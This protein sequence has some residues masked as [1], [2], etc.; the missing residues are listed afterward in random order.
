MKEGSFEAGAD[1]RTHRDSPPSALAAPITAGLLS[2]AVI[3]VGFFGLKFLMQERPEFVGQPL[4]TT[5]AELIQECP[6][7]VLRKVSDDVSV[8]QSSQPEFSDVRFDLNGR[9]DYRGLR[10]IRDM[11]GHF[12]GR[13]VLTNGFDEPGYLLFKCPHPRTENGGNDGLVAGD[14]KLRTSASGMQDNTADAWFWSGTLEP[15]G[16]ATLEVSYDVTSLKGVTYRVQG[17]DGAQVKQLR[18]TLQREDLAAMRVD[19]GDGTRRPADGTIVWERRDFLAPDFFSATIEE[20]RSLFGSISQLLEIGPLISLLFLVAVSA[21]L[22]MRQELTAFQM[23]TI[24]AGYAVYF[25]LLLYLAANI[26]FHW[27][28]AI[29]VVVPG[30]L[31]ANYARWLV[32]ARIGVLGA[33]VFLLLYQVFPT[34][35]AFAGWNR[36]MVLLCLGLV[37]LAVLI[38]LQNRTLKLRAAAALGLLTLLF[39]APSLSAAEVQVILPAELATRTAEAKHELTNSPLALVAFQ[40]AEYKVKQEAAYFRVEA[41]VS[42]EAI[43]AGENP[44][45]LFSAPVYLEQAK[46]EPEQSARLVTLTNRLALFI[47]R[48]GSGALRLSYRVPAI[49]REGKWHAQLPLLLGAPGTLRLESTSDAI[50]IVGGSVWTKSTA[51]NMTTYDIG[52]AGEESLGIEWREGLSR[53]G[54]DQTKPESARDIY[55]IGLTR[56]QNLTIINSDG[57]CTHFAEYE[58]PVSQPAEFRLR[59]PPGARLLSVSVNHVEI[60]S[61]RVADQVC[62]IRLPARAPQQTAHLVSFRFAYPP[63]P[64]GFS[65]T[66]ELALPELF[67]TAGLLEWAVALPPGFEARVL[68]CGLE[69]QK[70]PAELE[71]FGDYGRILKQRVNINLAKE[72][73][74]PALVK[75]SMKYRQT[76][77]GIFA[78]GTQTNLNSA[79]N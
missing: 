8:I 76:V 65:G 69:T 31:L 15:H 14:L 20:G 18:V 67:Q 55:G 52:V 6:R 50:E 44:V 59:L 43:R 37:T 16:T 73:A 4:L 51:N 56:A 13:Y 30:A 54:S 39:S 11:S 66:A 78:G 29:A 36:G 35:A 33:V 24:A 40:P 27:A 9:R 49:N 74:P 2:W 72:L 38:N 41:A 70:S 48:P 79:S 68:S 1:H 21:V 64:L 47:Q 12:L 53:A 60:V 75:L 77:P 22:L 32:G 23:F 3:S 17:Q 25:P 71:R 58:V 46:I 10:T 28:L 19:T 62:V 42:L 45:S 7:V 26:S 63:A 34:L 61:P 5:K 57:G